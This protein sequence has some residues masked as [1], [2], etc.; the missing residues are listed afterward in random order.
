[1]SENDVLRGLG[2]VE[3][4]DLKLEA[5]R[6]RLA[7]RLL[8][9]NSTAEP[10]SKADR[11][12]GVAAAAAAEAEL[13]ALTEALAAQSRTISR[14]TR[15]NRALLVATVVLAVVAVISLVIAFAGR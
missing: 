12:R 3:E 15:L 4:A 13:T 9:E 11:S 10:Q 1:M 2:T 5:L 7:Q 8:E 6:E 14:L